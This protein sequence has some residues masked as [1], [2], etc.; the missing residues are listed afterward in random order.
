MLMS[1][2]KKGTEY[3]CGV[4]GSTLLVS[5]EGYG[6]LEDVVCCEK[7]MRVKTAKPRKN[8]KAKA[9]KKSSKR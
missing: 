7:P 8:T 9:K 6:V 3:I 1:K 2:S 5:D 4:C